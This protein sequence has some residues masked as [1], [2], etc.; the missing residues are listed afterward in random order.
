MKRQVGVWIDH[1]KA[2]IVI[3]LAFLAPPLEQLW[4][5]I[6]VLATDYPIC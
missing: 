2:V 6:Q 1:R 5:A 3:L 4:E